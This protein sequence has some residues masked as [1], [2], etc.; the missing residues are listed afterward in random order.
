MLLGQN[1]E[2]RQ[3]TPLSKSTII[4]YSSLAIPL[5]ILNVS[6]GTYLPSFYAEEIGISMSAIGLIMFGGRL[7]DAA[8]GP[9][10]WDTLA[11]P[12]GNEFCVS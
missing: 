9:Q 10:S 8:V 7:W 12:E 3:S 5:A 1:A 6:L 11:D 4:S 2:M